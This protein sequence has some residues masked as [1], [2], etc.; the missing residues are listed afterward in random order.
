MPFA[1]TVLRHATKPDAEYL[2]HVNE[3]YLRDCYR[4][5]DLPPNGLETVIDAADTLDNTVQQV[6]S[7]SGL[8][9]IIPIDR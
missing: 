7:D 3:G 6:P 2:S 8:H 9:G 5:E 4:Q 1:E